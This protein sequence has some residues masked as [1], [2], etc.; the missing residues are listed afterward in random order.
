MIIIYGI[1][2]ERIFNTKETLSI[3]D[4]GQS[5]IKLKAL[6][7]EEI[8]EQHMK[9]ITVHFLPIGNFNASHKTTTKTLKK[10]VHELE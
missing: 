9:I 5:V 7:L 2:V 4:K 3:P 10:N 6:F 1:H 8:A